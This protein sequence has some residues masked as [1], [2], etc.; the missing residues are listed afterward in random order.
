[1]RIDDMQSI[2]YK[3]TINMLELFSGTTKVVFYITSEKKQLLA[4]ASLWVKPNPTMLN[5]LKSYLGEDNV[6]LK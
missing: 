4:P 6:V 3:K 5:E 2:K 1:M